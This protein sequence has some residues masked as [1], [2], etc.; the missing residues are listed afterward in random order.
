M[1]TVDNRRVIDE[2]AVSG[3][4]SKKNKYL[5]LV[6]AVILTSLLFSTLFSVGGSMINET[7]EAT[8]RQVGGSAHAGFKYFTEAE[9]EQVKED[10]KLKSITYRILV[11]SA[12]NEE[13]AKVYNE[14]YY[15]EDDNAR[16][17]FSYPTSGRMPETEDEVVVSDI[18][19]DNM[20]IPHELG[21]KI[22]LEI[23]TDQDHISHEFTLCGYYEADPI[24]LAQMI[25]V[26]KAFQEKYVPAVTVP[27][28]DA[29]NLTYCGR[30]SVD[31]NF[32]TS[33]NLENQVLK[34]MERTGIRED[35]AYG[36]NWALGGKFYRRY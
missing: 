17:C 7:Q 30:Y 10:P 11:G 31:F 34:L 20:G 21:S 15:A 2:L 24:A 33:I 9:Y 16:W 3:I 13:L 18:I 8:M 26:S 1:N 28:Q 29:K 32:A 23:Q 35:A 4:R 6:F 36:I 12:V 27:F 19:L 25:F 5:I 14:I 22:T